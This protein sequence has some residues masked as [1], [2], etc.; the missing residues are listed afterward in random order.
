VGFRVG[1]V[2][3]VV[4]GFREGSVE[5]EVVGFREGPVDGVV[6]T[7]G[8]GWA[9]GIRLMVTGYGEDVAFESTSSG[10][11]V[12]LTSPAVDKDEATVLLISIQRVDI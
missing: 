3:G 10:R 11:N 2:E 4:V 7:K 9:D 1:S 6:V 12:T 8:E 5:G